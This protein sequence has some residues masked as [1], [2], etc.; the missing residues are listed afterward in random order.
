ME[1]GSG[2]ADWIESDPSR[3]VASARSVFYLQFRTELFNIADHLK[4]G[5]P[6]GNISSMAKDAITSVASGRNI[7]FGL[8]PIR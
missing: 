2:W 8:K 4:F 5:L 6:N 3:S 7:Q 1:H